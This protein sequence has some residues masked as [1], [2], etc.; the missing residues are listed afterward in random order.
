VIGQKVECDV[1]GREKQETNHWFL[2]FTRPGA[3]GITFGRSDDRDLVPQKKS[4]ITEDICGESCAHKR[5][6]QFLSSLYPANERQS[7]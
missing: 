5:L 7:A 1:C 4:L 2:C 3:R 6:S